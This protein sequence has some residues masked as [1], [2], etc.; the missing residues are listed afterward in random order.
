MAKG[1]DAKLLEE[2]RRIA[3][4]LP[5]IAGA[6]P[7]DL[8]ARRFSELV[9]RFDEGL[10]AIARLNNER[11][12]AVNHKNSTGKA[13]F[14]FIKRVRSTVKGVYGDDS[15]EYDLVGGT[16]RSERKPPTRKKNP[17]EK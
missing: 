7:K 11:T 17:Q 16:R 6:L 10:T 3:Q 9:K 1:S 12:D 5:K 13:V 14:E 8:E 4:V 2:A 15:S